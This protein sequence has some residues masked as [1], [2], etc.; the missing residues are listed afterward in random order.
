MA[1]PPACGSGEVALF[2]VLAPDSADED[3]LRGG[4]L[5]RFEVGINLVPLFKCVKGV[6]VNDVRTVSSMDDI[7]A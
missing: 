1:L 7:E 4:I 5:L 2:G 6:L 3:F